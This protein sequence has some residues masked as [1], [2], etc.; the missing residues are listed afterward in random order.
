[1]DILYNELSPTNTLSWDTDRQREVRVS[2]SEAAR[3]EGQL[4]ASARR[5]VA[6]QRL[7]SDPVEEERLN[8]GR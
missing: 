5:G 1:M 4:S 6:V 8:G 7:E 2:V 3:R